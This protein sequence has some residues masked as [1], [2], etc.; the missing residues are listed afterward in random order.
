[1][2]N[3][4]LVAISYVNGSC[5]FVVVMREVVSST[6]SHALLG[7]CAVPCSGVACVEN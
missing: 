6:V 3:T 7:M 5:Y 1:V 4:D 2:I